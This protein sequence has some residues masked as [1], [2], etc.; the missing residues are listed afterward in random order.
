MISPSLLEATGWPR[1]PLPVR[2]HLRPQPW[3]LRVPGDQ[4]EA[5]ALLFDLRG[6]TVDPDMPFIVRDIALAEALAVA[7][8]GEA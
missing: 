3:G 7:W 4:P 6:W 2:P 8:A 1:V 5:C